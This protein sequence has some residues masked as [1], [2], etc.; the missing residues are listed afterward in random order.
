MARILVCIPSGQAIPNLTSII[1]YKPEKII[2]L[3]TDLAEKSNF[4]GKILDS[5]NDRGVTF[6]SDCIYKVK[7]LSLQPF[8]FTVLQMNSL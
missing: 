6:S 2:F 4:D 8:R 1:H 7:T 5:L 3:Q